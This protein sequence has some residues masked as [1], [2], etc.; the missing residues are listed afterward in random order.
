M[1]PGH[2]PKS[3]QLHLPWFS[4]KAEGSWPSIQTKTQASPTGAL[5]IVWRQTQQA[6]ITSLTKGPQ[7]LVSQGVTLQ[8]EAPALP[9]LAV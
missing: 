3:S 7:R 6:P 5:V 2:V 4:S 9:V 1:S 8:T